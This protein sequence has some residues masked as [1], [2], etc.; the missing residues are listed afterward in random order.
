MSVSSRLS[1]LAA[2]FLAA[3]A[4][5]SPA[6]A[7]ATSTI[8]LFTSTCLDTIGDLSKLD[9]LAAS[10]NWSKSEEA[11]ASQRKDLNILSMW[12]AQQDGETLKVMAAISKF[13]DGDEANL[14]TL[15]L[16]ETK[17]DGLEFH[18]EIIAS[19]DLRPISEVPFAVGRIG[20][21]EIGNARP[22]KLLLQIMW[23]SDGTPLQA[24]V[25]GPKWRSI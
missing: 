9:A 19:L 12:N 25:M 5:A 23:L 7:D 1:G 21:Y 24:S 3:A 10:R 8:R 2:L 20:V 16:G 6:K 22:Q 14:C 13:A 18:K 17:V 11:A 15:S 4:L